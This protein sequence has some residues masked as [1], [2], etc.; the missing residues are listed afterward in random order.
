MMT[1]YSARME[2]R[3]GTTGKAASHNENWPE[4]EKYV[5]YVRVCE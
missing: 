5:T 2:R 1:W 4:N 3:G